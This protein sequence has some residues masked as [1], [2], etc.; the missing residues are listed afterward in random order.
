[1][2]DEKEKEKKKE[3]VVNAENK[4]ILVYY[5]AELIEKRYGKYEAFDIRYAHA[6]GVF[7]KKDE[8]G[9]WLNYNYD[10]DLGVSKPED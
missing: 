5:I 10:V 9:K 4:G 8:D 2:V 7:S 1:M 3:G 6:Q